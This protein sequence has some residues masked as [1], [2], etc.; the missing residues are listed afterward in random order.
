LGN[1]F[2]NQNYPQS[3]PSAHYLVRG[4]GFSAISHSLAYLF[5]NIHYY[6]IGS[7]R[8]IL[9]SKFFAECNYGERSERIEFCLKIK[10]IY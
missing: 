1:K 2:L 4:F 9:G 5:I 8:K 6:R 3:V 10:I 7:R